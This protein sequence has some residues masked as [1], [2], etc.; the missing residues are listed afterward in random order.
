[1]RTRP[2]VAI[3][4]EFERFLAASPLDRRAIS[5]FVERLAGAIP[6]GTRVLDA[7]AGDSPYHALFSHCRYVTSDWEN[8]Q[9]PGAED[10]SVVAPID[11]LPLEDCSFDVVLNTQVLEHVSDPPAVLGEL[12]R[13]LVPGGE[14]WL[15]VPLV[16]E[17]HEEPHD[18]FRYT[19]HGMRLLL[20]RAGFGSI[21]IQ[22]LSGYFTTLAQVLRQCGSCT[23]LDRRGVAAR[24]ACALLARAAPTLARLDGFDTRR[25]LPLGYSC[26]ARR[27]AS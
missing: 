19:G 5:A 25:A 6:P 15:T 14:L 8:S 23:G 21:E 10:A 2:E 1:M 16:W 17:L 20:E 12:H 27:L 7:G 22:P 4:P 18:Y 3:D 13:L 26:R 24:A 11:R 9:H